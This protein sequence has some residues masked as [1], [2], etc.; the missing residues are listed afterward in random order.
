MH[1]IDS[2][3]DGRCHGCSPWTA[4]S[5]PWAHE[6]AAQEGP[7]RRTRKWS[8]GSGIC[9]SVCLEN[10]HMIL[11]LYGRQSWQNPGERRDASCYRPG[12]P[13]HRAW[14]ADKL[15]T[16]ERHGQPQIVTTPG[17]PYSKM[18]L[19]GLRF[20]VRCMGHGRYIS[21]DTCHTSGQ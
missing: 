2:S 4:W 10:S 18:P 20:P 21:R 3:A 6:P 17:G 11:A 8:R 12:V 15:N 16:P 5:C 14:H 9:W 1:D 7:A 19:H 13:C